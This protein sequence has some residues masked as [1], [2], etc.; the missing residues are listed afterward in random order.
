MKNAI[1]TLKIGHRGAMGYVAENTLES[2][3][4]AM[5]L[6]VDGIE[7]DVHLCAS[8][9]LVVFHDLTLDRITNG[10]GAISKFTLSE[11]K[12]LKI[13]NN[14]EIPT[15]EE[16]LNLINKTHTLNIELKGKDT[17]SETS[18]IIEKY[19]KKN[20]WNYSDFLISSFHKQELKEVRNINKSIPLAL[21]TNVCS[22]DALKFAET[23]KANAI[24]PNYVLLNKEYV[25][26][27]QKRGFKV[28]TW[29]VNN[30]ETIKRMKF[31]GVDAIISDFPDRL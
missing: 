21:L 28:N 19:I 12:K 25:I 1:K 8:G 13:G 3:Q 2:I 14:F 5:D 29:T 20:S 17:A 23:I 11:L 6:G 27:A 4:K 22:N 16:V 15:L 10:Q 7:I 26:E 31:Y 24:H 18:A 9:E 30:L